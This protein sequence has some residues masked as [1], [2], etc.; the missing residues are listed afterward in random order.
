MLFAG[1]MQRISDFHKGKSRRS[2]PLFGIA[3]AAAVR[4]GGCM[5]LNLQWIEWI[6]RGL[7]KP[8]KTRTGLAKALGRNPSMITA[9]LSGKRE[10]KVREIE[11]IARYLGEPAPAGSI[12]EQAQPTIDYVPI[13]GEVEAGVWREL[14][15]IG[16]T[17]FE[18]Y[19]MPV[20]PRW[21]PGSVYAFRIRGESINRRARDGDLVVCLDKMAAPRE[22]RDGDWVIAERRRLGAVERTVKQARK[23]LDGVWELWP[24]SDDPRH[25][26]PIVLSHRGGDLADETVEVCAFVLDFV[27][28]ATRF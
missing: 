8:G 26:T 5:G 10:L 16:D 1:S 18:T 23:R 4:F 22:L 27:R 2:F 24:D 25:R 11:T 12:N 21:P 7:A 9:L 28:P 19:P 13:M 6:E 17:E 20:D 3:P 14:F 15:D